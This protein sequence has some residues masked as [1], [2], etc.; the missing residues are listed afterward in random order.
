MLAVRT[1][2]G[3]SLSYDKVSYASAI[4]ADLPLTLKALLLEFALDA[5]KAILKPLCRSHNK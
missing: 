2:I 1:A 4:E 5:V 3:F